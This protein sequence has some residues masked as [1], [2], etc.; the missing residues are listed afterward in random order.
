MT[1][2]EAQL[3]EDETMLVSLASGGR[4]VP[5]SV[6]SQIFLWGVQ[7]KKRKKELMT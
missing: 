4:Q 1:K 6:K 5:G 7:A 3:M 2:S